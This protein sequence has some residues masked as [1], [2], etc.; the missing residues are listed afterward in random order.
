MTKV[1]DLLRKLEKDEDGAALIEY[2]ILFAVVAGVT[3][4]AITGLGSA[5]SGIFQNMSNWLNTNAG[6]LAPS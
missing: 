2:V 6:S 3:L 5:I 1:A 4:A